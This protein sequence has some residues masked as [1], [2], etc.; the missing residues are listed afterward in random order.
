[1][2]LIQYLKNSPYRACFGLVKHKKQ[3]K[4]NAYTNPLIYNEF[5][6][7]CQNFSDVTF[8]GPKMV[9]IFISQK[10]SLNQSFLELNFT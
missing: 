6:Q 4:S 2:G 7:I 10:I 8:T 1:M 9:E 5:W 3:K